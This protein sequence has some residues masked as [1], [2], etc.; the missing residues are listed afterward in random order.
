ML[1]SALSAA[2]SSSQSSSMSSLYG[3]AGA[4]SSPGA[5]GPSSLPARPSTNSGLSSLNVPPPASLSRLPSWPA[6]SPS[7]LPAERSPSGPQSLSSHSASSSGGGS[8]ISQ[9]ML[10]QALQS[11]QVGRNMP[12]QIIRLL[13]ADSAIIFDR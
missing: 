10:Q 5:A 2:L 12:F 4:H 7:S 6:S 3:G 9:G 8:A 1:A 11:L 13:V